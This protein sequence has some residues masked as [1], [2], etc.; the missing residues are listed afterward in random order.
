[1]Y[2]DR[3]I[4]DLVLRWHAAIGRGETPS[5]EEICEDCPEL[6][7][8]LQR[9]LIDRELA[10]I[11]VVELDGLEPETHPGIPEGLV[12][13]AEPVPGYRLVRRIGKG[14]SGDV[15]EA[16]G[17]GG[18]PVAMK[19]ARVAEWA[20]SPHAARPPRLNELRSLEMMRGIRH[21]NILPLFGAWSRDGLLI[22]VM[23]LADR[24]LQDR[25]L[26]AIRE[27][28][29]GIPRP[30][31][32]AYMQ[33]A[34]SGI[35]F[36]NQA[37]HTVNGRPGMGVQHGDIKPQNLLLVGGCV[38]VGDF[39]QANGLDEV[40]RNTGGVT[41]SFAP[42]ELFQGPMSGRSDQYSLAVSY[43]MLRGGRLPFL[44]TP[45][46]VMMGHFREDPDL[47]MLL[48]AE[49]PAVARALAK[50][51]AERWPDCRTFVEEVARA[52]DVPARR[53]FDP[54]RPLAPGL[55]ARGPALLPIVL[56]SM[57]TLA[58]LPTTVGDPGRSAGPGPG[59]GGVVGAAGPKRAAVPAPAPDDAA[60]RPAAPIDPRISWTAGDGESTGESGRESRPTVGEVARSVEA[61][62]LAEAPGAPASPSLEPDH[63]VV[64][65]TKPSRPGPGAST[66]EPGAP[67]PAVRPP[68]QAGIPPPLPAPGEAGTPAVGT[69][70]GGGR[71]ADEATSTAANPDRADRR[72][73]V[74]IPARPSGVPP[75]TTG[76]PDVGVGLPAVAKRPARFASITVLMP[77]AKSELVVKGEVG[78]GNP[79]EWYGPTRVIHSP[80]MD[81]AADYIVGAFWLDAAGRSQ[82]RSCRLRV[83]PGT[84]HEVDLRSAVPTSK[85]IPKD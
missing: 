70:A 51:P 76:P 29:S 60:G 75:V 8:A 63:R 3:N 7:E 46:Q 53:S 57:V 56:L 43:C 39:G 66:A 13:D 41:A 17:P 4:E 22:F 27:G 77:S 48:E 67:R 16:N 82:T 84:A 11:G 9:E 14:G 81:R 74:E 19:F 26:E 71:T 40:G 34:A 45:L 65:E 36:L 10:R 85:E 35:D 49:R 6:E 61:P 83:E 58:A 12:A 47:T 69:T 55:V 5:A 59:R 54:S 33:Q 62:D 37:R 44:G 30:E 23:E 28:E 24:T 31:L 15:W 73:K 21:P 78:R 80:P 64:V 42:P 52:R 79:D 25:Y 18:I 50:R 38:K 1:M 72:A 68:V 32:V 20:C 2:A